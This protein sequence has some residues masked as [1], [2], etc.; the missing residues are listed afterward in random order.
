MKDNKKTIE[1]LNIIINKIQEDQKKY[2]NEKFDISIV[3]TIEYYKTEIFTKNLKLTKLEEKIN[4]LTNPFK[5]K[6]DT[7]T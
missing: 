5:N 2:S 7:S 3:S 1:E 6:S 4:L